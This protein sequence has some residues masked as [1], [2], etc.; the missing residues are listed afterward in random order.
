MEGVGVPTAAEEDGIVGIVEE[1][2]AR[3]VADV[4]S[5]EIGATWESLCLFLFLLAIH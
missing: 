4:V 1:E 3:I 2:V 5:G